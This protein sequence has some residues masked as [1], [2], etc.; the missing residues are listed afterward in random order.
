MP[1]NKDHPEYGDG[2][3]AIA[4]MQI[5]A[6]QE[7]GHYADIMRDDYGRQIDRS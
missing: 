1:T 5:I 2:F 7:I 3:P 6:A 4:R